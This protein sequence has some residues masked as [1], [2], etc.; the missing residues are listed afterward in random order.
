V[1]SDL[2][3]IAYETNSTTNLKDHTLNIKKNLI[4]LIMLSESGGIL[5]DKDVLLTEDLGWLEKLD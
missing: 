3:H 2:W 5:I 1:L 4:N